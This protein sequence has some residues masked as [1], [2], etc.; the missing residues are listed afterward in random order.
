MIMSIRYLN[1][2]EDSMKIA[3]HNDAKIYKTQSIDAFL[4]VLIQKVKRK[5]I[6]FNPLTP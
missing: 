1:V 3:H 4:C 6:I 2:T 5:D